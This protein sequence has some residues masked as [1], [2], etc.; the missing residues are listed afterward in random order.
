MQMTAAVATPSLEIQGLLDLIWQKMEEAD[1]AVNDL[2][3]VIVDGYQFS[4][5]ADFYDQVNG[6]S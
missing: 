3:S 2:S 1:T 5:D 4:A 6:M